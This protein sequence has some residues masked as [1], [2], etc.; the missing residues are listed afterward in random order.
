MLEILSVCN[1]LTLQQ[2]FKNTKNFSRKL[3]CCFL[4]E[5]TK[6]E[7]TLFPYKTA[8]SEVNVKTNRIGST[9]W[10]YCNDRSFPIKYF[11]FSEKILFHFRNFPIKSWFDAPM[12]IFILFVCS[13]TLFEGAFFLWIPLTWLTN[14]AF[15]FWIK[16]TWI[17]ELVNLARQKS[18]KEFWFLNTTVVFWLYKYF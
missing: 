16:L 9:K 3:E 7:S 18:P 4:V 17:R 13:G 10:S 12:S 1:T 8:L 15:S 14:F 11:N 6:I 2:I 5:S